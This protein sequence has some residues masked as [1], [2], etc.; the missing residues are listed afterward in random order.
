MRQT[1]GIRIYY[2]ESVFRLIPSQA[3]MLNH[4]LS[5][6]RHPCVKANSPLFHPIFFIVVKL[7]FG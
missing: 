3:H 5:R 6:T 2:P 7:P 4:L 1:E